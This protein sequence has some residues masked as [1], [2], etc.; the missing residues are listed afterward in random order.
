MENKLS[1]K[2]YLLYIDIVI[3]SVLIFFIAKIGINAIIIKN[4]MKNADHAIVV[5]KNVHLYS[6]AK[7]SKKFDVLEIGANVYVLKTTEDKNGIKWNKVKSGDK[8][9]YVK[10]DHISKYRAQYQKRDLMIDVS[11]FNMQNTFNTIGE[12]KAFVIKN[13]IKFVYIR[14]GGRGYGKAGNFYTDSKADEYAEACEFLNIPF[15]YYFLE[16]AIS[17]QEVDEE[18]E[19]IK[20][21][22]KEHKYNNNTL[23]IAIDVEKHIEPGRA[24][25]IWDT[26]YTYVNDLLNKIEK[27]GHRAILYSNANIANKYLYSVN[28][29]MWLAYYP[30]IKKIPDGWY[31]DTEGEGALNKDLISKMVGWQFTEEGISGI[32]DDKIDIS[33]VYSKYFLEDNM[34]DVINDIKET[35][36]KVFGPIN[37]MIKNITEN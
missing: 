1:I 18:V 19:F 11:K 2:K 20:E 17:T 27:D 5:N 33:S 22:I 3:V 28:S 10:A 23:P 12:F 24:D 34:E 14:A 13:N 31:S 30:E 26:R 7:E 32:I 36:E 37:N 15:G 35:N 16:E 8:V 29:E 25:N 4:E 6:S 21:Y 9:G